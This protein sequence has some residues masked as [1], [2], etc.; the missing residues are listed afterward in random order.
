MGEPAVAIGYL[1]RFAADFERESGN[2]VI[3]E[4]GQ[5]KGIKVAAVGSGPAG[6]SFAGE[7]AK[8]DTMLPFSKLYT[9]LVEF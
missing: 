7:M 4:I 3:P 8:K 2:I 5:S 6:L 9:R 1:E